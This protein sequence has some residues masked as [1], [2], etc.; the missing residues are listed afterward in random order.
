MSTLDKHCHELKNLQQSKENFP[1]KH[2][3]VPGTSAKAGHGFTSFHILDEQ[4]YA[5]FRSPAQT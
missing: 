2:T 1:N 3:Y 4:N 5:A